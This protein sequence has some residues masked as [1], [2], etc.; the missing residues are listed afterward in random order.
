ME[1]EERTVGVIDNAQLLTTENRCIYS[2]VFTTER[3]IAALL[4]A[5]SESLLKAT[6]LNSIDKASDFELRFK[7]MISNVKEESFHLADMDP[8]SILGAHKGS[9][10]LPYSR[11]SRIKI[12]RGW[13]IS[14]PYIKLYSYDRP[15][16]FLLLNNIGKALNREVF[17]GYTNVLDSI[18]LQQV[19]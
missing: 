12:R 14:K 6:A 13:F 10:A 15:Y 9:F 3:V 1:S 16:S 11:I 17:A 8:L 18:G 7:N 4:A 5:E 19:Y 2:L